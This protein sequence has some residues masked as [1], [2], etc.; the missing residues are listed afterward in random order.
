MSK[1]KRPRGKPQGT[2][3]FKLETRQ[4]AEMAAGRIEDIA[5]V[6]Q[7]RATGMNRWMERCKI[8]ASPDRREIN[9]TI[10]MGMTWA[11]F[12]ER[13]GDGYANMF[14]FMR[15]RKIHLFD[16][17][18]GLVSVQTSDRMLRIIRFP[19]DGTGFEQADFVVKQLGY[20][21]DQ[22][23]FGEVTPTRMGESIRKDCLAILRAIIVRESMSSQKLVDDF[24]IESDR[25]I[26]AR[27]AELFDARTAENAQ[28]KPESPEPAQPAAQAG[29]PE[30]AA[31]AALEFAEQPGAEDSAGL[32]DQSAGQR[33]VDD[34]L[35]NDAP[36]NGRDA[37]PP[38]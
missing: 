14:Q 36:A 27:A 11:T 5:K 18:S 38:V 29:E 32:G 25:E 13:W 9:T 20:L 37:D 28:S 10:L 19:F 2:T 7:G 4:S 12:R 34:V 17:I 26:L 23:R 24:T 3:L 16:L 30:P 21:L 33:F 35:G 8:C 31:A 1:R 22:K 6:A 15:H